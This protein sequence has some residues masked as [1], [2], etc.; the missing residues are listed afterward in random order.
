MSEHASIR[1]VIRGDDLGTFQ[2]SNEAIFAAFTNGVLRNTS[3][4]MPAPYV[5]QA[6]QQAKLHPELCL[7]LHVTLTSEWD[8]P[9]WG[10]V[11]PV[12]SVPS[13]VDEQGYFFRTP[14]DLFQHGFKMEEVVR[15]VRAQLELSRKLGLQL[16]YID[17]HMGVG[18]IFQQTK[19][20]RITDALRVLAQ[21][22]KLVLDS[23]LHLPGFYYSTVE[24]LPGY[25]QSLSAGTYL[26][27]THPMVD[28]EE[29]RQI[30]GD[31]LRAGE[32]ARQR[33]WDYQAL[34]D[35][36]VAQL[37]REH[38]VVLVHYND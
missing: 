10:P 28:N 8:Q 4:M 14:M 13:L 6:A 7:G 11:S 32:V 19:E 36:R 23:D 24:D 17:E 33:F 27:V 15:E 5:E 35:P 2:A 34:C 20:Y 22:E 38:E 31:G 18:W 3:L 12:E 16:R 30:T 37:L 29:A 9:R 1:L 26:W 25:L 21:E